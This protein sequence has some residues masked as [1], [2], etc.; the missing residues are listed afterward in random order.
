MFYAYTLYVT[1][2]VLG[3]S[4]TQMN[5]VSKGFMNQLYGPLPVGHR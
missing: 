1:G 5:L 2:G 4:L 3:Y